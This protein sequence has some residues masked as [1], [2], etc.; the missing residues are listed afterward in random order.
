M[1]EF[2]TCKIYRYKPIK[3]LGYIRTQ[4]SDYNG[5][6][7]TTTGK[8]EIPITIKDSPNRDELVFEVI[9]EK[10]IK[11][12]TDD[13]VGIKV[14]HEIII[15]QKNKLMIIFRPQ[16]TEF[17][18]KLLSIIINGTA[19][20]RMFYEIHYTKQQMADFINAIR[21]NTIN[22]IKMKDP[23]FVFYGAAYQKM[24]YVKFSGGINLC[25]TELEQYPDAFN[26]CSTLEPIF[27]VKNIDELF[28]QPSSDYKS[29]YV[30]SGIKFRCGNSL[31]VENWLSFIHK[32]V[33]KY[34][35]AE[36]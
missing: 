15:S 25:A 29:L 10:P 30:N 9:T 31:P 12:G 2:L 3:D 6:V 8:K 28:T 14:V 7:T 5:K 32:Y 18:P 36:G 13:Y 34:L 16:Q 27:Y 24:Y 4:L 35:F 11:L 26:A 17:L 22:D 33:V 20:P 19:T 1:S 21:K 23:R